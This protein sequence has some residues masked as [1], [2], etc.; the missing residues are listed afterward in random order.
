[1]GDNRSQKVSGKLNGAQLT[2]SFQDAKDKPQ[3]FVGEVAGKK[4]NASLKDTP[5]TVITATKIQ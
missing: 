1:M 4:I 3:I 2:M 5:T